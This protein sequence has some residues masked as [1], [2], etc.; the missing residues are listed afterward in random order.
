[1][2]PSWLS[3]YFATFKSPYEKVEKCFNKKMQD[4]RVAPNFFWKIQCLVFFQVMSKVK[5]VGMAIFLQGIGPNNLR[6]LRSAPK[7]YGEAVGVRGVSR[8]NNLTN[9][10]CVSNQSLSGGEMG[11]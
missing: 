4:L 6:Q 5:A 9:A 2:S 7:R 10:D 1:M 8:N 11:V 3:A